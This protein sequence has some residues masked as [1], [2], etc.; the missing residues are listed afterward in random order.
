[1]DLE[2]WA[3]VK[4]WA[5]KLP[6][7]LEHF[8]HPHVQVT[9]AP[10]WVLRLRDLEAPTRDGTILRLDVY[11]PRDDYSPRPVILSAH[12][13]GKDNLPKRK[14]GLWGKWTGSQ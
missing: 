14:A 8:V 5:R 1:M 11:R 12:P 13:Y 2:N 6:A 4:E 7:F 3:D 9:E 10:D